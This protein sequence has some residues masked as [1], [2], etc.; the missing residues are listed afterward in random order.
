MKIDKL[1]LE[2]TAAA[3]VRRWKA[4][5]EGVDLDTEAVGGVRET[6]GSLFR[7]AGVYES[8]WRMEFTRRSDGA[9]SRV[10]A[11][12]V[13]S[14]PAFFTGA[15]VQRDE[16]DDVRDGARFKWRAELEG[17]GLDS[18]TYGRVSQVLSE[19]HRLVGSTEDGYVTYKPVERYTDPVAFSVGVAIDDMKSFCEANGKYFGP[20]MSIGLTEASAAGVS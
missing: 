16:Y 19:L 11:R 5:V 18:E 17:D 7:L 4:V 8:D 3:P 9:R 10:T 12:G 15:T 1:S 14:V 20:G 13:G 6:I 2:R